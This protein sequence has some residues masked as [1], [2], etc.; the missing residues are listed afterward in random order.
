[1]QSDDSWKEF[2]LG[3]V[4]ELKRGY[5]LPKG[6]RSVGAV[7]IVSSS[8]ISDFHSEAM[9]KGPGVVTGRYGTIG[10]VYYIDG[11]FWPLNTT[12]YVRDFKGS[13]PRF[14]SYFLRTLDFQAYS[15]KG[16][17]PGIN[18]N[19]LHSAK[20]RIPALPVQKAIARILGALDSKI[21][22]NRRINQTLEAMAQAIFKSWFVDFDPVKA[23]ITAIEQGQDP[24]RAAMRTISG[25]SDAEL[26]QIPREQQ[27]QLAATAA[28]FPDSMQE[29]ELGEIPKGWA[30]SALGS[31]T[32]Y[33]NRGISPKYLEN[34]GVLVLNQKCIRDFR[35]D[36]SK[37]RRHDPTQ[38]K[39]DGRALELGDVLVNSTGV[40]TLGRVAQVLCLNELT[41]VDSH[42]TVVRASHQLNAS[43]LG[44]YIIWKH[45]D[46]E[47]M[48]DGSTGQ[49]ELSRAKLSEL[50]VLTP[51]ENVL[52][53]FD[54]LISPLNNEIS[55][56]DRES[57]K[58][59]ELRGILL[60]KLLSGELSVSDVSKL[61]STTG[62]A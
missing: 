13:D 31:V 14:I 35:V 53:A 18:R 20:V 50:P 59:T 24:L 10:E 56:N 43:Y 6:K 52:K 26:D 8:G 22:L 61:S 60:P 45:P 33:L 46:I 23:K 9:V 41:I 7:P 54:N 5:D 37:G 57:V 17:V 36:E 51:R 48:G 32:D 27:D 1:M 4:I 34:G 2:N 47:A 29:S 21:D 62:A 40:G 16:A 42:V 12:L 49:T 15:D 28:L 38:R 3:D 44:Q 19:H 39:I 11:D 25:K 58:L 55:V 30:T